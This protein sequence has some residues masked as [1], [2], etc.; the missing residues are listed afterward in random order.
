MCSPVGEGTGQ[1]QLLACRTI[2]LRGHSRTGKAKQGA[3]C[4]GKEGGVG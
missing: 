1:E 2:P 4:M 3:W